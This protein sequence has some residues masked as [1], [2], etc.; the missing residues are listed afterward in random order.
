MC[1][2]LCVIHFIKNYILILTPKTLYCL[3]IYS[4]PHGTVSDAIAFHCWW[5]SLRLL[6]NITLCEWRENRDECIPF[7][8]YDTHLNYLTFSFQTMSNKKK[9]ILA[10]LSSP[11]TIEQPTQFN[12]MKNETIRLKEV[13][14]GNVQ[15]Q[16]KRKRRST[17]T[18]K[19]DPT[20]TKKIERKDLLSC[21]P[22]RRNGKLL[23]FFFFQ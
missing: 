2:K 1:R 10:Y 15:S 11:D 19:K 14:N 13:K 8:K 5:I 20:D 16:R 18:K 23:H 22:T 3:L 7:Y 9:V 4:Q 17:K 21:T 12:N 6:T